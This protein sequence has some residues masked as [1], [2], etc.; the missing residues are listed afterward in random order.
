MLNKTLILKKTLSIALLAM[1]LLACEGE[2]TTA[3]AINC[4]AG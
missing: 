1:G 4:A 3:P 2:E